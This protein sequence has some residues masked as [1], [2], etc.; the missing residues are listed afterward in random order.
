[1]KCVALLA[2]EKLIIDR[3]GTHS[4]I[5]VMTNA[6]I[7]MQEMEP[8]GVPRD[9]TTPPSN[10]VAPIQWW[11][12]SLWNP[13]PEDVGRSFEQVYQLYWPNG[14]KVREARLPFVQPSDRLQQS[15]FS[16]VGLPVGQP[17]KVR[18]VTWAELDGH[19]VTD[20]SETYLY[21]TH[22]ADM[23]DRPG[24]ITGFSGFV[25]SN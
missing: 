10:A 18:I 3:E 5:N 9:V 15:S 24:I 17:G 4:I 6:N 8:G 19:C 22:N 23:K 14:E 2:C 25:P 11:V 7:T 21:I 16:F 13:S 1:M 20:V 12:Y